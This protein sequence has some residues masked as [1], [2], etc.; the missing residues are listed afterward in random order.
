MTPQRSISVMRVRNSAAREGRLA[1]AR[2][3]L[4]RDRLPVRVVATLA[5]YADPGSFSKAFKI[6]Y[7]IL[8]SE[9]HDTDLDPK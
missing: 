9:L 8:P 2:T 4:Q 7:G 3:L 5:G 6:L 1:R